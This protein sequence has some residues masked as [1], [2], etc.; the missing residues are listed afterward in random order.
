MGAFGVCIGLMEAG[1]P[2]TGVTTTFKDLPRTDYELSY[3]ARRVKGNDFF[4][5]ATFPVGENFLTFVNGGWGGSVTGISSIGG[6]DA[7]ENET[8]RSFDYKEGTW[9]RFRVRVTSKAVRCW[10]DTG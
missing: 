5:A 8:G 6:A 1:D 10:I 7:S 9:Y 3:E 2:M 4:A